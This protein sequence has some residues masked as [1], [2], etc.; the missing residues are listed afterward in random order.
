MEKPSSGRGMA[1]CLFLL[2]TALPF[3]VISGLLAL[4]TRAL[5]AETLVAVIIIC[6]VAIFLYNKN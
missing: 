5:G 4:G 2:L 1:G 6:I 3:I